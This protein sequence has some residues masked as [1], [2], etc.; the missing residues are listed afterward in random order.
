MLKP[1]RASSESTH[2]R[3]IP[4]LSK[5]I[6]LF[7]RPGVG[8]RVNNCHTRDEGVQVGSQDW[9]TLEPKQG[10]SSL[11]GDIPGGWL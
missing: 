9:W 5:S 8:G 2:T 11:L 4:C 10:R 3:Q 1:Q 6:Q 7:S